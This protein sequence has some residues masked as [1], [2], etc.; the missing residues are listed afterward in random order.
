MEAA[1]APED[2]PL[3][4]HAGRSVEPRRRRGGGEGGGGGA[5]EDDDDGGIKLFHTSIILKSK[6]KHRAR[7]SN[8]KQHKRPGTPN[9]VL[10]T[11]HLLFE[12]TGGQIAIA[13]GL[14]LMVIGASWMRKIVEVKF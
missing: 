9:T 7:H 6:H 5:D 10:P 13:I 4:G 2:A 3:E 8:T 1:R 14:G 11:F 12:R